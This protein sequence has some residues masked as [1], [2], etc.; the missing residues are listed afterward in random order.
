MDAKKSIEALQFFVTHLT[1]GAFAHMVQGKHFE[2][3]GL[4]KLGKKYVGHYSEE[5]GRV[6][7]FISRIND[8]GGEVK[9]EDQKGRALVKDPVDYIKE[10]LDIQVKGVD[11]LR[12]CMKEIADDY[13]T[14]DLLKDYLKD[15]EEDLFWSQGA[16]DA[17][18]MI[19]KQNW[20]LQQL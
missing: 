12:N 10:D 15:E 18:E 7:D 11:L 13:V 6:Q 8:L 17:I 19:G 16:V 9:I 3:M 20:L 2:A 1:E 14:F 4:T 5:M